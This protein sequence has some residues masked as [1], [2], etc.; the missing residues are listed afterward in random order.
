MNLD[1]TGT[2]R[3]VAKEKEMDI[4]LEVGKVYKNQN[5]QKVEIIGTFVYTKMTLF[6]GIVTGA[7]DQYNQSFTVDGKWA[8]DWDGEPLGYDIVGEW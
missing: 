8:D 5:G 3:K 7:E 1:N 4:T 2:P 6:V